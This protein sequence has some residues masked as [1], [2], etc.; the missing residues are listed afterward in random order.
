MRPED[1]VLNYC[2][3]C[4]HYVDFHQAK[5]YSDIDRFF[6]KGGVR[7]VFPVNRHGKHCNCKHY[8]NEVA[9]TEAAEM[10]DDG[11]E[12]PRAST[13]RPGDIPGW[14]RWAQRQ[15]GVLDEE[16]EIDPDVVDTW[17]AHYR[18]AQRW[19]TNVLREIQAQEK[20]DEVELISSSWNSPVYTRGAGKGKPRWRGHAEVAMSELDAAITELRVLK[21]SG[22]ETQDSEGS[23]S[24]IEGDE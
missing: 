13:I 10:Y 11:I 1:N 2:D 21:I 23:D 6:E 18:T 12:G 17:I 15:E 8:H 14:K 7:C 5:D 24:D 3:N 22:K 4:G 16:Y 9:A 20:L 19:V